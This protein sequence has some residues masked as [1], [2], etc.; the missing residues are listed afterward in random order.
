MDLAR[1][2]TLGRA[3]GKPWRLEDVTRHAKK[4]H[5]CNLWAVVER[6][7]SDL[8]IIPPYPSIGFS[9]HLFHGFAAV[10]YK[11]NNNRI[12]EER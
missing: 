7:V 5:R 10:T 8:H 2:E 9:M 11:L 3:L 6:H 1:I 12:V 4:C